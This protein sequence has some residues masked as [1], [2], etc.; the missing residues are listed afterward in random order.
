MVAK[1]SNPFDTWDKGKKNKTTKR[2]AMMHISCRNASS[3]RTAHRSPFREWPR[4]ARSLETPVF[5][6]GFWSIA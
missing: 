4:A 6:V 2:T 3:L 5:D 1:K